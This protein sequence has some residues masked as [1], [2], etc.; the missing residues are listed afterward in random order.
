MNQPDRQELEDALCWEPGTDIVAGQPG[1]TAFK[2]SARLH[3]ARW[4]ERNGYPIGTQ[5][6]KPKPN[7]AARELGSRLEHGFAFDTKVN[8]LTAEARS[9]AEERLAD[10]QDHQTLNPQRLWCDL[11]SSMPLCFNLFGPLAVD[12]DLARQA[13]AAWFPDVPGIPQAVHLEWS[14]GRLD[15][16]YLGNRTAFDAAI[17]LDLGG[18]DVG[19]LGIETKYHEH[20]APEAAPNAQRL[21]RY[22]TVARDSGVFDEDQLASIPGTAR[23]QIWTDHLLALS[24]LTHPTQ[25]W[26]WARFVVVHPAGNPSFATAAQDYRRVLT[27]QGTFDAIT[28]ETLLGNPGALPAELRTQLTDRYLW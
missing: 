3:Q 5:P 1:V 15:N 11:L 7:T 17:E 28:L 21:D 14:P 8:L 22:T 25:S 18:G 20:A 10:R 16:G 19:I 23:Q 4:R 2:Q 24:M 6:Y 13:T 9:A 27:D 26:S 12:L